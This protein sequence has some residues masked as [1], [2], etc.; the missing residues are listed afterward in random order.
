MGDYRKCRHYRTP[1][2]TAASSY[3]HRTCELGIEYE[4]LLPTPEARGS[5]W[6]RRLP[7]MTTSSLPPLPGGSSCP[8]YLE[9][10]PAEAFAAYE[11]LRRVADSLQ[12]MKAGEVHALNNDKT[13]LAAFMDEKGAPIP[14]VA[15]LELDAVHVTLIC[16][17]GV[18]APIARDASIVCPSCARSFT[19]Q[20]CRQRGDYVM[21]ETTRP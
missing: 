15:T 10:T 8:H 6:V 18:E 14:T 2:L 16:T 17:C 11:P 3:G 12:H 19:V 5:G 13:K 9:Q 7:C 1:N 20:F 4:S 21:T